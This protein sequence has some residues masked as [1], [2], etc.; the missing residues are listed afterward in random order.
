MGGCSSLSVTVEIN[1]ADD[2]T[3]QSSNPVSVSAAASAVTVM[4][5]PMSVPDLLIDTLVE[6]RLARSKQVTDVDLGRPRIQ[7]IVGCS[8][9]G[10][11]T[12]AVANIEVG[13][14][15]PGELD[16]PED[17]QD[18]KRHDDCE[19]NEACP[20]SRRVCPSIQVLT[21][22]LG[23][24]ASSLRASTRASPTPK[25]VPISPLCGRLLA[26]DR[27]TRALC[28]RAV[29]TSHFGS[30]SADVRCAFRSCG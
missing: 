30:H 21:V 1:R 22:L 12:G 20:V 8:L 23:V 5:A 6:F 25:G 24:M 7:E 13:G 26:T 14:K 3:A 17:Q 18:E 16:Y 28:H 19:L 2:G 10:R 27:S 15:Q 29:E 11:L 4:P 9:A